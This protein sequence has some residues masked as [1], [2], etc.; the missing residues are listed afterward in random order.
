MPAPSR[1]IALLLFLRSETQEALAKPLAEGGRRV[2]TA[3]Y[4]RLNQYIRR[5]ARESGLPLLV[6][7]GGRQTGRTFGERLANAFEYAFG[8][9]Y[10]HVIA[11]GNDCLS[12]DAGRLREAAGQLEQGDIVFGPAKDGGVYLLGLSRQAFSRRLFLGLPWQTGQLMAALEKYSR[13]MCCMPFLLKE[14]EDA[15]T[16]LSFR[17]LLRRLPSRNYLRLALQCLLMPATGPHLLFTLLSSAGIK[18][19]CPL[20]GPPVK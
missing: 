16:P 1:N 9:G 2:N 13:R 6:V 5:Q 15:D 18:Q 8:Q 4:Q 19:T 14:E 3:I 12:L 10:S 20:R 17:R 7:K 11:I